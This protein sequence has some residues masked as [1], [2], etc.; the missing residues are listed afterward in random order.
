MVNTFE[1]TGIGPASGGRDAA[2]MNLIAE[3]P[4][5]GSA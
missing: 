5:D 3:P 4:R 1:P 2:S